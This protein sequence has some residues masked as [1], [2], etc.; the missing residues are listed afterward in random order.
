MESNS[1]KC[2][3]QRVIPLKCLRPGFR[4]VRLRTPQNTPL[5]Y[6]TLF[7]YSRLE[8]EEFIHIDEDSADVKASG[9][10]PRIEVRGHKYFYRIGYVHIPYTELGYQF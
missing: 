6:A 3:A 2:T 4:H 10:T 1:N 9:S 7:I 5:E 8:E